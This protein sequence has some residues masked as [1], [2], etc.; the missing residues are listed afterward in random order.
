MTS[1][2]IARNENAG[3]ATCHLVIL[4]ENEDALNRAMEMCDRVTVQVWGEC[5]LHVDRWSMATLMEESSA[6][7]AA[8]RAG[9]ADIVVVAATGNSPVPEH[10]SEWAEQWLDCR[11]CHEGALVGLIH[12]E[13]PGERSQ[14]DIH[15]HQLALRAGMDYLNHLPH[16]PSTTIPDTTGWCATRAE[17]FTGTL[18]QIIRNEPKPLGRKS[19]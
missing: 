18:D 1:E 7:E 3:Y 16:K 2:D 4:H 6:S 19:P 14:W 9:K 5:D 17:T 12:E 13:D 10:F 8:N 15:L 11:Q